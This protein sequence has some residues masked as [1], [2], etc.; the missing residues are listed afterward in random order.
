MQNIPILQQK[1]KEKINSHLRRNY[2]RKQPAKYASICL[3]AKIQFS[4]VMKY[5][6]K[7]DDVQ[8]KELTQN[9]S[10]L[11]ILPIQFVQCI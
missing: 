8:Q 5:P 9:L 7:K 10:L 4:F 11:I 6:F 3:E 2:V 1:V